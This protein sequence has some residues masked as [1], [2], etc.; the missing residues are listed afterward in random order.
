VT[1]AASVIIFS[2]VAYAEDGAKA[3]FYGD[4]TQNSAEVVK[5]GSGTAMFNGTEMKTET[6]PTQAD[7]AAPEQKKKTVVAKN[8]TKT[9]PK[10]IATGLS[11][12]IEVIKPNGK[13]DR[14]TAEKHS[15]KSGERIRFV[16]KSNKEGYLY[17][18]AIGSSGKGA[19]L[20]PD[21]RI[22][23]GNNLVTAN[24]EY[25]VPF[26]QKSF[27]MDPNPGN[28]KV[29]VFFSQAEINDI[30]SYFVPKKQLEA[31]DTRQIYAFAES[32]G[33]KDILFEEDSATGQ[34][35]PASY[36]VSK[37]DN[38]KNVIFREITVR[39]K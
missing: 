27:V 2:C 36:I 16:F 31:Q 22:N 33:S 4:T 5:T 13:V 8:K 29:L 20:F 18:L 38:P 23:N 1:V 25:R 21:N 14:V 32:A 30:N 7:N 24:S 9:K 12:F 10:V 26:G 6:I 11:Y 19:I 35:K 39:H 17:L 37:D 3:L 34:I 15:F 28:E